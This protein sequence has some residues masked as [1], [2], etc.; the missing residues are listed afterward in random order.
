MFK[1]ILSSA[2]RIVFIL[3]SMASIVG[4]FMKLLSAEQ[5]L[6]LAMLAFTFYFGSKQVS[7]ATVVDES[8]K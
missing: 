3:M 6:S 4:F 2:S 1:N 7:Q 8:Q 5:F